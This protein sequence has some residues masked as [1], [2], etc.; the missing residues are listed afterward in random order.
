MVLEF[1]GEQPGPEG[2]A[3]SKCLGI[4]AWSL[5][6]FWALSLLRCLCSILYANAEFAWPLSLLP[7]S[8]VIAHWTSQIYLL[9]SDPPPSPGKCLAHL[10][11]F[12]QR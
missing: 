10:F 4:P 2:L 3:C 11:L 7:L 6:K 1:R 8:P 5:P 12:S 9:G